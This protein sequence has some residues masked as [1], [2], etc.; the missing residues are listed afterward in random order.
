MHWLLQSNL[1]SEEGWDTLVAALE[2]LG[3]PYSV[4]K[5]IPFVGELEPVP[6][7]Q[8]DG[9]IV[10]GSYT[11]ANYAAKQGWSPGA[12]LDNLDF[13]VQRAKWGERMLNYDARV[14]RF[15]DV[16]PTPHC[17]LND[18]LEW[19]GA[20][21]LPFFLRPVHDTK[22]FTGQVFDWPTFVDWRDRVLS[23]FPED[24]P[25]ITADTLVMSCSKKEIYSETRTWI[26][27]GK[28][29]TASGYKLG[30]I[31]RYTPPD[32]VEPRITAFAQETADLWQPNDAF[33]LDVAD[34]AE[35][36]RICEVNNLN[37]AGFYKGD[38]VKLIQ[39]LEDLNTE[40][41]APFNPD[42]VSPPGDTIRDILDEKML[43]TTGFILKT[44][45]HS[46]QAERLLRGEEPLTE[47]IAQILERTIGGPA[48][49]WIRR[50]ALYRQGGRQGALRRRLRS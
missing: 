10:M 20:P 22:S 34:T 4:H 19:R 36:L 21:A 33:V 24:Y 26:V 37:S 32:A 11:L 17:A 2:R 31:K 49:F 30:T 28:V 48:A 1:Y 13:E 46:E 16:L 40:L 41:N 45:L 35:G 7:P 15:A 3:L 8:S 42:W 47:E 43:T 6:E 38:V 18:L 27:A 50:E 29:V 5:V 12:Y 44:G 23:L 39:A 9:I 25:T 14:S